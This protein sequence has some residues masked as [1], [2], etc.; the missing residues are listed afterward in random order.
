MEKQNHWYSPN[1][2]QYSLYGY[3]CVIGKKVL[4]DGDAIHKTR[5][6]VYK[7]KDISND[8]GTCYWVF[9]VLKDYKNN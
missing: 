7:F 6:Q 2:I 1:T 4:M 5:T 9:T 8:V 3:K